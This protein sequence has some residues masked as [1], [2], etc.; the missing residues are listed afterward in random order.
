MTKED[1]HYGEVHFC[2][3]CK[4]IS[5]RYGDYHCA[6]LEVPVAESGYCDLYEKEG[7][8]TPQKP[9]VVAKT[10]ADCIHNMGGMCG[11]TGNLIK[12]A[13]D[14]YATERLSNDEVVA[15]DANVQTFDINSALEGAEPIFE[16]TTCADAYYDE[17]S[18]PMCRRFNAQLDMQD[19]KACEDY[20]ED[21]LMDAGVMNETDEDDDNEGT[22][23]V[24]SIS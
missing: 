11:K 22:I 5:F 23:I 12:K 18:I 19:L 8:P 4:H 9:T 17:N 7:K 3:F 10:C 14:M 24:D 20:N 6:K 13:C 1:A 2:S 15:E 21:V 16:C